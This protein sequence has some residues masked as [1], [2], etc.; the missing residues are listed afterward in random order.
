MLY[1]DGGSSVTGKV[2][3]GWMARAQRRANLQATGA[4][5]ILCCSHLAMKGAPALSIRHLAGH[6]DLQT[7]LGYMRLARGETDPAIGLLEGLADAEAS[8]ATGNI[9]PRS[10]SRIVTHRELIEETG[11]RRQELKRIPDSPKSRR[12]INHA[13]SAPMQIRPTCQIEHLSVRSFVAL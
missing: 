7:T 4:F 2:L 13:R 12:G 11:W 8:R 10:R 1:A 6:E 3:Q 5:H 9:A